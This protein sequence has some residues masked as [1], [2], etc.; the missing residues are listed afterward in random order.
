MSITIKLLFYIF[1]LIVFIILFFK[2]QTLRKRTVFVFSFVGLM[3]ISFVYSSLF[4][5]NPVTMNYQSLSIDGLDSYDQLV[6]QDGKL[7]DLESGQ[8]A[9]YIDYLGVVKNPEFHPV[10]ISDVHEEFYFVI[11]SRHVEKVIE[12][13]YTQN[14]YERNE[15]NSDVITIISKTSGLIASPHTYDLIGFTIGLD[16]E[17]TNHSIRF[18]VFKPYTRE[19]SY[20]FVIFIEEKHGL[21]STMTDLILYSGFDRVLIHHVYTSQMILGVYSDESIEFGRFTYEFDYESYQGVMMRTGGGISGGPIDDLDDELYVKQGY[22]TAIDDA[23]YYVNND[24]KIYRYT[25][26]SNTYVSDVIDLEHWMDQIS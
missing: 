9:S 20:Y 16:I 25:L 2:I 12:N 15:L 23:I 24:L 1:T 5:V 8:Y 14:D 10:Y 4:N 11:F 19:V 3:I 26:T 7:M 21:L 18:P 13:V 22:F 17:V 6:I